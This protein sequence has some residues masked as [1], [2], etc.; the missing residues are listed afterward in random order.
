MTN[1]N[2]CYIFDKTYVGGMIGVLNV[3][4]II[5]AIYVIPAVIG[6]YFAK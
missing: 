4:F 2:S 6:S 1:L 3:S 5:F